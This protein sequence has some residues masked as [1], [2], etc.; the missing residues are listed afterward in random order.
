[1]STGGFTVSVVEV[2]AL[3]DTVLSKLVSG[4]IRTKDAERILGRRE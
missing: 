3:R 2:R 4:K 1:M